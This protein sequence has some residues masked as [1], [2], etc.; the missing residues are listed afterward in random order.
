MQL[1]VAGHARDPRATL[2]PEITMGTL[3]QLRAIAL[4]PL[5]AT[6]VVPCVIALFAGMRHVGWD[7]PP[8]LWFFP[9]TLAALL[10]ASGLAL[11]AWTVALFATAGRGTLAPWDP[12]QR[13]VVA[14]P[15]RHV[16]NPMI[17]GVLFVL[18]GEAAL[19]GSLPVCAWALLFLAL[20][21][22]YIPRFEEPGLERRFGDD[23][24]RY[25]QHV[26][27]WLPRLRAWQPR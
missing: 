26:P 17:S 23:Y 20:N 13:L 25:K 12:T 2:C 22:W 14:G 24:R 1:D 18:L 11:F 10:I 27:R 3:R 8:P 19:L 7:L 21:H 4:L 5:V 6:V 16:R 9:L 15:Y